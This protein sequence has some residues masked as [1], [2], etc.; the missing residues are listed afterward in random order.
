MTD[1]FKDNPTKPNRI[2]KFS[3]RQ[4]LEAHSQ[5][6]STP[7]LAKQ[8]RVAR[9]SVCARMKKL[10]L[11]A[12]YKSGGVSRYERVGSEQFSCSACGR[13]KPL[14]ERYGTICY[15]CRHRRRVCTIE[16]AL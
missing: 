11:K 5:G 1:I 13:A 4:L 14:R 7:K 9:S 15:Q 8:L 3:D 10:G 6:L 2:S 16:G 12:N